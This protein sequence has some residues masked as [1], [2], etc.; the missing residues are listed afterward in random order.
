[1]NSSE[2]QAQQWQADMLARLR[3][4]STPPGNTDSG[5]S[6]VLV[7]VPAEAGQGHSGV[8]G[9]RV[10]SAYRP[11]GYITAIAQRPR[12]LHRQVSYRPATSRVGRYVSIA[13]AVIIGDTAP[14]A[15]ADALARLQTPVPTGR[16]IVVAGAHGG[17]GASTVALLL[18]DA[19][20]AYRPDGV[21]LLDACGHTGGL[22]SRLPQAPTMSVAGAHKHL[23]AGNLGAVLRPHPRPLRAVLTPAANPDVTANV[24]ARLQRRVGVS[25]IDT[26]SRRLAVTRLSRLSAGPADASESA[27]DPIFEGADAAV[28]V[29]DNTVRG[30]LC[31]QATVMDCFIVGVPAAAVVVV[32]VGRVT[33]SGI[34]L[35]QARRELL[36][37]RAV[38]VAALP[39]D[40]HLAGG[41]H[42]HTHLLAPRTRHA[43]T[44]LAAD[45]IEGSL[46]VR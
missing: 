46:A 11:A 30:V 17:A 37:D 2:L 16:R 39:R 13:R 3:G 14:T 7:G 32:I 6:D 41:A 43:V 4:V 44:A 10:A 15:T 21:V 38:T 42:V 36:R 22:L 40:R 33:D 1:M 23:N 27:C 34:T 20:N 24:A 19:F 5:A 31:A 18:A 8:S 35:D 28:V 12:A 25:V 9:E 26:G 45:V 29:C